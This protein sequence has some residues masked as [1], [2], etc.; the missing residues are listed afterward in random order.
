MPRT[1]D[2]DLQT[3]FQAYKRRDKLDIHINDGSTL[4]LSRGKVTGYSNWLSSVSDYIGTIDRAVDRIGF[5]AQNVSSDLGLDLASNLRLLD[6]AVA[7][8]SKQYQSLRNPALSQDISVFR[9]VLANAEA[10][11]RAFSIE[12]IVDYESVGATVSSRALS[13]RCWW[14]YKNGVECP[15]VS[16]ETSCPKTREGCIKRGVEYAFGGWEFFERPV[17]APPGK[18]LGSQLPCFTLDTPVWLPS[19][20]V[21]IGDLPLGEL[22]DPIPAVSFDPVTGEIDH[23]DEIIRV[24]EHDATGY[25]TFIFGNGVRLRVT[26]DHRLWCGP[27]LRQPWKT[28]DQWKISDAGRVYDG[29]WLGLYLHSIRWNSDETV[30]VRNL[31]TRKNHTYF[32]NRVAVSNAKGIEEP[33]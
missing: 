6:Y 32:A 8:Y 20:E 23:D 9:G 16:S 18:T 24:W 19:G 10:N 21:P 30:R 2:A 11:E 17:T 5:T 33:L 12:M 29:R 22:R 31:T 1:W 3:I 26:P 14:T 7:E 27:F 4:K 15:S 25:F 13:P 28:A